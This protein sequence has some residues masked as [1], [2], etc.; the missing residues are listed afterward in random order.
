MFNP[1]LRTFRGYNPQS[2]TLQT[3]R[4]VGSCLSPELWAGTDVWWDPAV[5]WH[6]G[7]VVALELQLD[8]GTLELSL[9]QLSFLTHPKSGKKAWAVLSSQ[10]ACLLTNAVRV[11]G[12]LV[13]FCR[14]ERPSDD[15]L[16]REAEAQGAKATALI[17]D[18]L[19]ERGDPVITADLRRYA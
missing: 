2:D 9:K 8:D 14:P 15:A 4:V 12:P 18:M 7:D 5:P 1:C 3:A 19:R 13:A 11:L 16:T 10:P 6:D 17:M